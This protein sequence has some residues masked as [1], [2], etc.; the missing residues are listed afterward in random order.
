[1]SVT[2][3]R[4]FDQARDLQEAL[5]TL[6]SLGVDRILT[7]GGRPTALAGIE[8]LAELVVRAGNKIVIM[9][10]G[11][12]GS[13]QLETVT[14]QSGVREVH[15]GSAVTR[16]AETDATNT[17]ASAFETSWRQTDARKVAA[18]VELVASLGDQSIK[19]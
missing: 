4:A 6:I 14:R 12:L 10:G 17:R 15:L 3:H 2:F 1:M 9:A 11:R 13:D 18:V 19:G 7:S 16:L 8:A 5:G